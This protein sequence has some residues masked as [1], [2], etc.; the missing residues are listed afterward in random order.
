MIRWVSLRGKGAQERFYELFCLMREI[1]W[2]KPRRLGQLL[3]GKIQ[4]Y[5]LT[6]SDYKEQI[7]AGEY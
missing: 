1:Q 5:S 3:L 4:T 6:V 7:E 2:T